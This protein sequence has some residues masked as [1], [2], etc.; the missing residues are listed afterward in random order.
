MR[1]MASR[2][3]SFCWRPIFAF[4]TISGR[5]STTAV[6]IPS[7]SACAG[8][9]IQGRTDP[10]KP[11]FTRNGCFWTNSTTELLATT[12]NED[13]QARTRNRCNG[14]GYESVALIP[15]RAGG[16]TLGLLQLNDRRK[17]MF[18]I[19][20]IE[21]YERLAGY[22]AVSLAK[23]MTEDTLKESEAKYRDLFETVQEVF[24][25][26]HLIYDEHGNVID[27]IFE[28]MNPAGFA[29]LGLNRWTRPKEEKVRKCSV[30]HTHSICR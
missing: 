11:F 16:E 29:L 17:G 20:L 14:E 9:V 12:T 24:Y 28:D 3:S 1:R 7:W 26:D 6:A 21:Q 8:I 19:E 18:T 13:R 30:L 2:R 4:A 15:L 27:W 10:S 25:I 23:L 5:S 22:L